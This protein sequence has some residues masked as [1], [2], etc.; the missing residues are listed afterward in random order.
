MSKNSWKG[1]SIKK[2]T[3]RGRVATDLDGVL[4][5]PVTTRDFHR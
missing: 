5:V 3:I 2:F 1:L 4:D